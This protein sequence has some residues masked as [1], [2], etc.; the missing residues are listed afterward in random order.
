MKRYRYVSVD[1]GINQELMDS[2]EAPSYE[3]EYEAYLEEAEYEANEYQ[4]L[5]GMSSVYEDDGVLSEI[6]ELEE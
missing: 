3:E 6:V 5:A 2:Y 4:E 1:Y